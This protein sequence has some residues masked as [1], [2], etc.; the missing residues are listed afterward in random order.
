MSEFIPTKSSID[1][2]WIG[3]GVLFLFVYILVNEIDRWLAVTIP[4]ELFIAGLFSIFAFNNYMI[5]YPGWQIS[6]ILARYPRKYFRWFATAFYVI[7]FI[8]LWRYNQ[9]HPG[10]IGL[11]NANISDLVFPLASPLIS[12]AVAR[13]VIRRRQLSQTNR[14]LQA[15]VRRGERERIARDLHDTLGQSF[16][17]ITLKTEL[18][19]KLLIKAPERVAQELDDIAKTSRDNLQLVRAIVN[20]LHQQS[21]SEMM[22]EQGKNLAEAD[23]VLLTN[24]ENEA[25]EWP[26]T[27]QAQLSAVISEAI[28]NV[29]RHAHAHQAIITFDQTPTAYLVEVQD[30]GH[31][32]S[33]VRAGSNG[34]SG[35]QQ[36]MQAVNGTFSIVHNRQ[37]HT[38]FTYFAKGGLMMITLY[39]AEDQSMLNSA[40]SQLL[41][42][43]DDLTVI[44]SAQ[45]GATAWQAIQSQPP[46]VAI[47]DI[48]MPKMTGLDVADQIHTHALPTKVIILTTFAQKAYFQR[49][50]AAQVNGYLLKDSPSD[51][52]IAVIRKVMTGQTVYAPELVANMVTA[53]SNP[54]TERELAV[55][56]EVASGLSSKQIAAS[57]FLSE[58]TV[59]NYLSAIFS[60]LGV[61]NRIEAIEMAKRNKWLA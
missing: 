34:I 58:G 25:T 53:E 56:G 33:Y 14:R 18:A 17:M 13:S 11:D 43:E 60:K 36:R 59:R 48:E 44:G 42:L 6:F 26:T 20:D 27:V 24:G 35:M 22:L 3:L 28:T 52:L 45:D 16:S 61:H 41:N 31:S 9:F 7:I 37:G 29:I 19:K 50:I 8:G 46:D 15:V 5:I 57:L 12:Y 38:G 10:V 32:K 55:L 54:L 49:A 39:L 23:V 40:L 2:L 21:L 1:W 51:D 4:L 30:D 47:L